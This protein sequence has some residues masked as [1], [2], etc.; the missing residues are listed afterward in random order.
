MKLL[1]NANS[2]IAKNKNGENVTPLR[3]TA[4]VLVHYKIF[5][6]NY[7]INVIK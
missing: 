6:T 3:M 7:I 5:N 1:E 2:K 4:A